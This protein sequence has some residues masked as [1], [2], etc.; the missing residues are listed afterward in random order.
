MMTP[1]KSKHVARFQCIT[2]NVIFGFE[3]QYTIVALDCGFFFY[4]VNYTGVRCK[5]QFT[6]VLNSYIPG[7]RTGFFML[8]LILGIK[9][10]IILNK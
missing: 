8:S 9:I 5:T 7:L 6:G 2:F 3:H 4:L 10:K 1:Y